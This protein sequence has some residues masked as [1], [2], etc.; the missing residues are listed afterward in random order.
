MFAQGHF[1]PGCG[2]HHYDLL[3]Q[4]VQQNK[5]GECWLPSIEMNAMM[6]HFLWV[7]TE[8]KKKNLEKKN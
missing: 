7:T 1:K 2:S 4:A 3:S 6:R 8:M 5:P